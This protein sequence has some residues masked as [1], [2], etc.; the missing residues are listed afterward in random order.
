MQKGQV[1]KRSII[2]FLKTIRKSSKT[3]LYSIPFFTGIIILMGLFKI[4]VPLK[5]VYHIF[6]GKAWL[7]TAIGSLFGSILAGNPI[8]SYIIADFL[9]KDGIS[10]FAITSF[11]VA[12]VTVGITQIPYEIQTLGKRFTIARN[13]SSFVISMFV[14]LLTVTIIK[15]IT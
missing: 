12:W 10:L 8:N 13:L 7:D 5:I 3:M 6:T 11:I 4:F 1:K 14:S 9:L 2:Q 15:V